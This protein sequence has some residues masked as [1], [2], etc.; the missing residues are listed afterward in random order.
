MGELIGD[1]GRVEERPELLQ[2]L[3]GQTGFLGKLAA[4]RAR[5]IFPAYIAGTGW[6]LQ[7]FALRR[8]AVLTQQHDLVA[9]D[10]NHSHRAPV[11]HNIPRYAPAVRGGEHALGQAQ[12]PAGMDLALVNLPKAAARLLGHRRHAVAERSAARSLMSGSRGLRPAAR[13][14]AADT[15][16]LKSGAGRLGRLLNSG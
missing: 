8:S 12:D 15:R 5:G 14:R 10:G 13:A 2:R 11:V 9:I 16:P 6:D 7:Q 1:S 4:G 3:A